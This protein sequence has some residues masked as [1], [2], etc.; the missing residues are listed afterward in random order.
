[1]QAGS[2]LSGGLGSCSASGKAPDEDDTFVWAN[3]DDHFPLE[4]CLFVK[5]FSDSALELDLNRRTSPYLDEMI[6]KAR[7]LCSFGEVLTFDLGQAVS[8]AIY[9]NHRQRAP[10]LIRLSKDCEYLCLAAYMLMTKKIGCS[11]T[12]R[13]LGFLKSF[14]SDGLARRTRNGKRCQQGEKSSEDW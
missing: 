1:M 3:F 7:P 8:F 13:F 12:A 11:T 10:R 4:V 9:A 2:E 5:D 14:Y 6:A